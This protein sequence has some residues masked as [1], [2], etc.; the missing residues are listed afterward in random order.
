M[1]PRS[2][3]DDA[4]SGLGSFRTLPSFVLVTASTANIIVFSLEFVIKCALSTARDAFPGSACLL[5]LYR[6]HFWC[7]D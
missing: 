5:S 3:L 4:S 1:V 2:G 6:K 7:Q